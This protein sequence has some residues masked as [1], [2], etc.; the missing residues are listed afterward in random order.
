MAHPIATLDVSP[1]RSTYPTLLTAPQSSQASR[2]PDWSAQLFAAKKA[3]NVTFAQLAE[4]LGRDEVAVAA[5]FYG[6]AAA[7]PQDLQLLH[8]ALG[9]S[10]AAE[11]DGCPNR[12]HSIEMPPKEPLIY[13]LYEIVQNYGLAYKA[14]INE[15]MGDGIMSA[16]AFSTNVKK[17]TDDKGDWVVI[18]MRGKWFV[19]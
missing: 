5:L 10:I 12:G 7:S 15:L 13:R 6:Q 3:R 16:I 18:T 14:V 11:Y 1:P 17:E 19:L 4:K 8:E 9:V 2:V